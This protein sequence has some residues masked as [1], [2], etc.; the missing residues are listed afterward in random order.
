LDR[1]IPTSRLTAGAADGRHMRP[2]AAHDLSALA[3]RGAGL[4]GGEFV[5]APLGV[6]RLSTLASDL[7]LLRSVH[8][9]E[10]AAALRAIGVI[11]SRHLGLSLGS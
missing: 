7:A 11:L 2:I 6:R 9:R 10:T 8:R 1:A 3:T 5:G 4:V